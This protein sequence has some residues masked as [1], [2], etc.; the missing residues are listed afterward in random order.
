MIATIRQ[1]LPRDTH[2]HPS[3]VFD[4]NKDA[5][6]LPVALV[7][8]KADLL[9]GSTNL[10]SLNPPV[11]IP[12]QTKME[13]VHAGLQMPAEATDPFARLRVLHTL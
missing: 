3:A 4:V 10:L 8:N 7:V 5:W 9:L 11:L 1:S 2:V 12:E 6:H 13:L